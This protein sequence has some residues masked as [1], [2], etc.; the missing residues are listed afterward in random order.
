MRYVWVLK[1]LMRREE[2]ELA[3]RHGLG[4]AKPAVLSDIG[5]PT[6]D[7]CPLDK[8]QWCCAHS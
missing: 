6:A 8:S 5:C 4:I 7:E 2:E 1:L 3:I